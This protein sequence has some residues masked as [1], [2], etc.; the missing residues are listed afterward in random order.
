[1]DNSKPECLTVHRESLYSYTASVGWKSF[2]PLKEG[3]IAAYQD[4]LKSLECPDATTQLIFFQAN[5]DQ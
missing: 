4:F 5:A 1:M 2:T 3:L